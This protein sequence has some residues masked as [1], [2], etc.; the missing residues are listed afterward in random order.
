MKS[1][2]AGSVAS[3][4][5]EET[6]GENF[7]RVARAYPDIDALVDVPGGRRW[8]YRELDTEINHV[9]RGL[10]SLGIAA[11]DRVGI[12]APNCAEWVLV[13]YATAKIGAILVNI[14][15]AYRTHELTYALNQ[16]GVRTLICATA[17]K[18]S[19]YVAMTN[20][21]RPDSSTLLDVV[22][23]GTSDWADLVGGAEQVSEAALRDRMS[24]L[25]NTDPINIQYTSGTTG[26][27]KGA[28][29]SHRNVLN[30]G[31][32]VTESIHLEA[33]DRL[34]V[35][36]PFY[37]CFG[38]VLGN[39]GCTTHGATIV[40][41]APGFDPACTLDAIERERCVGV[42]GV[43]T[44]FIAM[45]ADPDFAQRDLSSLRTGIMAGSVCPVEVMKRCIDELRMDEVAI[46]YGMTETSPVSC[47]TLFDDDLERRTATVG[48]A[49]PHVEVQVVDPD[50]GA[51][52]ERGQSGELC[53]RGYSVML[54]YWNDEEH[55]REVIDADGWM[56]TGDL[57][58]MREDGYCTIIGRI[59]D[60]VIRGGENIS[61]REI[62]EF[63]LT[64]PDIEDV[65]VVGV[66]DEKYGEELCAWLRMRTGCLALDAGAVRAFAAGRLAHYKI[67]RYVHIVDSFPMTVTGK[68]RKVDM[69]AQ[70]VELLGLQEPGRTHGK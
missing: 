66:P 13:Q 27:P 10:M 41:P 62:E 26:Y 30:N 22:F 3:P 57:A 23:I 5:I 43:P 15:P 44:M 51:V 24:Q 58:V 32:F 45:L 70:A 53:T 46:A 11:G 2:D 4:I 1:Y 17:F 35:P 60:M 48:R 14:N 31:Y 19:D 42:Y 56:H 37:H 61:P 47:Q 34:C 8:T 25:S 38:M 18:S 20:Q 59:K 7:E 50:T 63:L 68:V 67:P 54:G 49:H 9:A 39:L 55:T 64:H 21:V 6:I 28:T 69:R 16:S 65:Q 36:V 29:L 40:V 52:V 33:G 12:W